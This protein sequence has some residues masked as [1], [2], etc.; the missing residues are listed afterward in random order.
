MHTLAAACLATAVG[1]VLAT[2][3]S[4]ATIGNLVIT[5]TDLD[6][7]DGIS[8][9]I[10]FTV[11]RFGGIECGSVGFGADNSEATQG[12]RFGVAEDRLYTA[13]A[14]TD[15]SASSGTVLTGKGIGGFTT[16]SA[17]GV[18]NSGLDSYGNY[19]AQTSASKDPYSEFTL[20]PNTK[21]TFSVAAEVKAQTTIG[22]NLET[23]IGEQAKALAVLN[24]VGVADGVSQSDNQQHI[25]A[26]AFDVRDDNTTIGVSDAWSGI[27]TAN[28]VNNGAGEATGIL[29]VF[30]YVDGFSASSNGVTPVPEP[31]TYA[32]LL[33]GLGLIGAAARRRGKAA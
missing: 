33:G 6:T 30:T 5:L 13:S 4:S 18:A 9:W 3:T 17:Q 31:S 14:H 23:D 27:L 10:T 28:F 22:Y 20:S 25:A 16:L 1:P 32:M 29:E 8:P 24:V 7:A 11:P 15:W 12:F 19:L 26:A 2:A 21:L